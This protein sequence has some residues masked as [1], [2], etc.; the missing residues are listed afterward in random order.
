M[1]WVVVLCIEYIDNEIKYSY[2]LHIILVWVC[3]FVLVLVYD[4]PQGEITLLLTTKMVCCNILHQIKK[5]K[6]LNVQG[7][8]A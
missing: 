1:P 3:G 5:L 4:T 6:L 8:A 7:G 2:L